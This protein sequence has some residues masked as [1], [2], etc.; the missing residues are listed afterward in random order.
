MIATAHP[1]PSSA[2]ASTHALASRP[3]ELLEARQLRDSLRSLLRNEQAAMA[4]FLVALAGFDRRR[5]WEPLG[6]ASLFAFLHV[7]LQ[8]SRS[9]TFWRLSAARL[10]QRFPEII[11]P[12]RDGRLCLTT[13]AEL[14]KVLTEEN[15]AEVLPRFFGL[16]AREAAEATAALQPRAQPPLRTVVTL[17]EPERRSVATTEAPAGPAVALALLPDPVEPSAPTRT[18]GAVLTPEPPLTQPGRGVAPRD[19]VEPLTAD[20]RRLHVTVSREFLR[21]L[22]TARVGLSHAIP[23]ATTEQVLQVALR[24]LLDRQARARG[25]VKRPRLAT[26][27][28]WVP[29]T[30][31]A[32]SANATVAGSHQA[33]VGNSCASRPEGGEMEPTTA[34]PLHRRTEPRGAISSAVRRAVWERDQGRCQWPLD[35]GGCCGSTHRLELDHVV[36]WALGGDDSVANLRVACGAH[37]RLAARQAFGSRW[38]ERYAG[39]PRTEGRPLHEAQAGSPLPSGGP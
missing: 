28:A 29:G 3:L 36:P 14:A 39:R 15:R 11:E 26:A 19:D 37:N 10:L 18:L 24:L 30:V 35:S 7:E 9:A 21:E 34:E 5:G 38:V 1:T 32:T 8:L 31:P 25:Q 13:A 20:L 17:L 23:N 22:E 6:H 16:S 4:D 2:A 12:L 27:P 33:S